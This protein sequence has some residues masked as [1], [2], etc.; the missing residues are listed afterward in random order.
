M[1]GILPRLE[2]LVQYFFGEKRKMSAQFSA[3]TADRLWLF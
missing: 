3:S 1:Q 2:E